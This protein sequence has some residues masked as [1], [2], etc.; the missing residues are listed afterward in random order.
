MQCKPGSCY[1]RMFSL[2]CCTDFTLGRCHWCAETIISNIFRFWDFCSKS[3]QNLFRPRVS[4]ANQLDN[5]LLGNEACVTEDF[6][7]SFVNG[8]EISGVIA[9]IFSF[10]QW[11]LG[12][13]GLWCKRGKLPRRVLLR[14]RPIIYPTNPWP[15]RKHKGVTATIFVDVFLP[16]FV[17]WCSQSQPSMCDLFP[18]I[19]QLFSVHLLCVHNNLAMIFSLA[20]L[21]LL[22]DVTSVKESFISMTSQPKNVRRLSLPFS[23]YMLHSYGTA[24]VFTTIFQWCFSLTMPRL[25]LLF[26]VTSVKESFISM[27]SQSKNVRILG[28]TLLIHFHGRLRFP[29]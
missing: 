12:F 13:P 25:Y 17:I 4:A 2:F 22:F 18:K 7:C 5:A 27:T 26:D 23:V 1:I 24:C 19:S 10:P 20:S 9:P 6:S 3:V 14:T 29:G 21:Y 11:Y 28:V 8:S 15:N 16:I